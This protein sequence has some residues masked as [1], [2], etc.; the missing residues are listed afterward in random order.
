MKYRDKLNYATKVESLLKVPLKMW[1][2]KKL[3]KYKH[4]FY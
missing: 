4:S 2:N 3:L 1:Q